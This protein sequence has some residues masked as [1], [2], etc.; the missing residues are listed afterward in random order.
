M[1]RYKNETLSYFSLFMST[2]L[3]FM[4]SLIIANKISK[5]LAYNSKNNGIKYE[6]PFFFF[7]LYLIMCFVSVFFSMTETTKYSIGYGY[8][9][10]YIITFIILGIIDR[11]VKLSR[12]N[13]LFYDTTDKLCYTA[14]LSSSIIL[15]TIFLSSINDGSFF[16]DTRILSNM[17]PATI[18][19]IALPV[20][21]YPTIFR[22]TF[23]RFIILILAAILIYK[24]GSRTT[25]VTLSI[26]LTTA[27]FFKYGR[28]S[29]IVLAIPVLFLIYD[30]SLIDF[31]KE[32]VLF[33]DDYYRGIDS[34]SGRQELWTASWK[35][36]QKSPLI[37]H[38]FRMSEVMFFHEEMTSAHNAYLSSLMETGIIGTFFLLTAVFLTLYKLGKISWYFKS[39]T[40]IFY[41]SLLFGA[42]IYGLGER[43]IINIGNLTSIL[44]MYT[45]YLPGISSF[46]EELCNENACKLCKYYQMAQPY[47]YQEKR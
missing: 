28:Y 24:G 41:F 33:L 9:I 2:I 13:L 47:N 4:V 29:L 3:F 8:L 43:F 7:I 40:Y 17:M 39:N 37:G 42:V 23:Y 15:I 36:F 30:Q 18:G 38:G 32:K 46:Q 19:L 26:V 35:I 31:V 34:L 20:I 25:I 21:L 22:M 16:S 1:S 45:F 14:F 5:E 27:L 12:N 44:C 11:M 6:A 10:A